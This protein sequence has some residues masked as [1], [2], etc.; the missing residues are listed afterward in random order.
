MMSPGSG[1]TPNAEEAGLNSCVALGASDSFRVPRIL[2]PGATR[3]AVASAPL[4]EKKPKTES[5]ASRAPVKRIRESPCPNAAEA[6]EAGWAN[7]N[8]EP[9]S[10]SRAARTVAERSPAAPEVT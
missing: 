5:S 4:G 1:V 7:P 3:E 8:E 10:R 2:P 6:G 9:S